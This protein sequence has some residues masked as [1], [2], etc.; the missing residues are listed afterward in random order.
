VA[1]PIASYEAKGLSRATRATAGKVATEQ[2]AHLDAGLN[3]DADGLAAPNAGGPR[4]ATD[5]TG[6][7]A[8]T[9]K[10]QKVELQVTENYM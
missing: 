7:F 4:T 8:E 9:P 5:G 1:E 10:I 3:R 2:T 6:R